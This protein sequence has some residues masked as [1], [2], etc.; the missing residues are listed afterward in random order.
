MSAGIE[1]V[2]VEICLHHPTPL[3]V[4][5]PFVA[6]FQIARIT[7][8]AICLH[9][10]GEIGC[11][12]GTCSHLWR[13]S[14]LILIVHLLHNLDGRDLLHNLFFLCLGC[15]HRQRHHERKGNCS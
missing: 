7:R 8:E 15:R 11:L 5:R 3:V 12:V 13:M 14:L 2:E 1:F 4:A 10:G 6:I 9:V